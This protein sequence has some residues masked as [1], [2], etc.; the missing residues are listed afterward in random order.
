MLEHN[1]NLIKTIKI[2]EPEPAKFE[3][4]NSN[5]AY[6]FLVNSNLNSMK[7]RV[8]SSGTKIDRRHVILSTT[9][10]IVTGLITIHELTKNGDYELRADMEDFENQTRYASYR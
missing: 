3:M 7:M 9:S 4:K 2:I 10:I 1:L 6:K 5:S 8:R